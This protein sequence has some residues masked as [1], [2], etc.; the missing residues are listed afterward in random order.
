MPALR[1]GTAVWTQTLA[2]ATLE[3]SRVNFDHNQGQRAIAVTVTDAVTGQELGDDKVFIDQPTVNQISVAN[4]RGVATVV[5]VFARFTVY[6]LE[7]VPVASSDSRL[8]LAAGPPAPAA[9][10]LS[11]GSAVIGGT[12]GNVLFVGPGAVFAQV[13]NG[14]GVL[15]N[16]GVGNLSWVA[17]GVTTAVAGSWTCPAGVAVND[18][19][20]VSGSGA[21]DT[22]DA[23]DAS[24]QPLIGVVVSKPT[25][26]TCIVQYY[27]EVPGFVGL[28]PNTTYYLSVTPGQITSTP[29]AAPGSI[30]QRIGFAKTATVLVLLVDRDYIAQ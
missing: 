15:T 12:P 1:T 28:V 2:A 18:A 5:R 10:S 8:S 7:R 27:G 17:P 4:Y 22:A 14:V 16:D 29:P 13:P 25:A 23:D 11:I 26:F 3:G 20:Y 21:C 9:G 19:V 24:K 30:I 6:S